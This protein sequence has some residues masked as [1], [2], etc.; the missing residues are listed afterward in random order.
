MADIA[1]LSND[2]KELRRQLK[3]LDQHVME[4]D[5]LIWDDV[6]ANK[7]AIRPLESSMKAIDKRLTDL[8]KKQ[9][10]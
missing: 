4:S 8:E 7:Q 6:I 3:N 10:K 9:K 1:S 5:K 2:I